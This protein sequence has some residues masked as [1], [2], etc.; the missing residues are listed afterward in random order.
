MSGLAG[1][2]LVVVQS[3]GADFA[4]GVCRL[5][6]RV[7][8][9]YLGAAAKIDAAVPVWSDLPVHQHLEIAIILRGAQT[10]VFP[11]VSNDAIHDLPVLKRLWVRLLLRRRQCFWRHLRPRGRI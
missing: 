5:G 3:A 8:Y 1:V 9:L 4:V 7:P 10:V 11:V 6:K 2:L